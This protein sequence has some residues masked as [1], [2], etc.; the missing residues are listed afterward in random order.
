MAEEKLEVSKEYKKAFNQADKL[1]NYMP[2]VL[3]GLKLPEDK[4]EYSQGFRD[5]IEM[6]HQE[7]D[8]SKSRSY[9]KLN[10]IYGKD[11]SVDYKTK[12]KNRDGK[13]R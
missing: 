13:D 12:S 2:Q 4:S 8:S 7:R 1:V 10:E 9:Q 6:Y 5:R 11:V 3:E